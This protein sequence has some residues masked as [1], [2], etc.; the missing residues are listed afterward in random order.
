LTLN[1]RTIN[2]CPFPGQHQAVFHFRRL[3]DTATKRSI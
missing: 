2:I 1:A 3:P